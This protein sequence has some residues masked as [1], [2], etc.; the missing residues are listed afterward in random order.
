[1][2][3]TISTFLAGKQLKDSGVL[4][5]IPL[6]IGLLVAGLMGYEN[7]D[8]HDRSN[9]STARDFAANYLNPAITMPF[10]LPMEITTLSRFGTFRK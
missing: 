1:M 6:G 9:R 2:C 8:D 3:L 7:W 5:F 4:A 10:Y